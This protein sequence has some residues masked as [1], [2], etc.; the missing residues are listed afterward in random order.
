MNLT[1][2]PLKFIAKNYNF[3]DVRSW[4]GT[5]PDLFS[6]L[7]KKK[8][9]VPLWKSNWTF[10]Y[11]VQCSRCSAWTQFFHNSFFLKRVRKRFIVALNFHYFAMWKHFYSLLIEMLT[12]RK[13]MMFDFEIETDNESQLCCY[14]KIL[15]K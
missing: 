9:S 2:Y 1:E 6:K 5:H 12:K 3:N 13:E 11:C 4:S 14:I 7:S 10:N 15:A 8:W